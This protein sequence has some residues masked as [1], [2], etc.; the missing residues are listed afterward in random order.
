MTP[1]QA[2]V[3]KEGAKTNLCVTV[4]AP[5]ARQLTEVGLRPPCWV[6]L[7]INGCNP[8]FV[9]TRRPPSRASVTVTL[10]TW[11]F[12][13]IKAGRDVLVHIQD[14]TP[15]RARAAD[16]PR[17]FDWLPYV[18]LETYFPTTVGAVLG[19]HSRH[20]PPFTLR[21]YPDPE[22]VEKLCARG[23]PTG[24]T[25]TVTGNDC[26]QMRLLLARM[27]IAHNRIEQQGRTIRV[28]RSQPLVRLLQA[29][30]KENARTS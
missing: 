1:F 14:A 2:R 6:R 7:L 18:D 15:Y 4:P 12:P 28:Q 22:T 21:R 11:A 23:V 9:F 20:E 26:K 13:T 5:I 24:R 17:E 25:Y 29:Y 10:P 8:V 19:L 16:P 27:G 30:E 3:R